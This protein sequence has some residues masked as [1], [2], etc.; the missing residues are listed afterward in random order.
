MDNSATPAAPLPLNHIS[1]YEV[2]GV[3]QDCATKDV[4]F[5]YHRLL[6]THHPDKKAQRE[7]ATTTLTNRHSIQLIQ[8]A[9]RTLSDT[10]QRKDYDA[11]IHTHFIKLG[12][13]ASSASTLNADGIDRIDLSEFEII[14]S[15]PV[16][17]GGGTAEDGEPEEVFVH[18]CPRCHFE[19][20]FVL[21]ES[22]LEQGTQ[23]QEQN[24][25]SSTEI[26]YQLLLQCA[27]CSL[28][29][30]VTYSVS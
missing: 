22:D 1:Y 24:R 10:Q 9:Y 18:A 16:K 8:D 23:E 17:E 6:L 11:A 3:P 15:Q 30:C 14:E 5:A 2:L 26:D 12:L 27:S 29:L 20:G 25:L 4:K 21:S 13:T 28:W 7:D 19:D